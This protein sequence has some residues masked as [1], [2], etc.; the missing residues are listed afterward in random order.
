[1][2]GRQPDGDGTA[3]ATPLTVPTVPTSV[4]IPQ[5]R[6]RRPR[7]RRA[8]ASP[9]RTP[10]SHGLYRRVHRPRTALR[11]GRRRVRSRPEQRMRARRW[12]LQQLRRHRWFRL[13]RTHRVRP[14]AVRLPHPRQLGDTT[15]GRG[16]DCL[17]AGP[18]RRHRR[19]PGHVA[20]TIGAFNARPTSSKPHG[21]APLRIVPLSRNDADTQLYRYWSGARRWSPILD[22]A[23]FSRSASTNQDTAVQPVQPELPLAA[24]E[25]APDDRAGPSTT[26]PA[27]GDPAVS[28]ARRPGCPDARRAQAGGTDNRC[29][30]PRHRSPLRRRPTAP[31]PAPPP[32]T[33][34]K[35]APPTT[36]SPSTTPAPPPPTTAPPTTAPPTTAPPTTRHRRAA[37]RHHLRL[38]RH[39]PKHRPPRHPAPGHPSPEPPPPNPHPPNP[40]ARHPTRRRGTERARTTGPAPEPIAPVVPVV[41]IKESTGHRQRVRAADAGC[42]EDPVNRCG[43]RAHSG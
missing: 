25:P 21:W 26:D 39:R 16:R 41:A 13:L 40:T 43:A 23:G 9:P 38:R 27:G 31:N 35:P 18:S 10:P 33:A 37:S 3:Q 28:R 19:I 34:P 17:G 29:T 20:I 14:P 8:H 24:L 22:L 15:R 1:M 11:L 32:T 4:T 42:R 7:S 6:L 36:T 2:D 5:Q 30:D 12:R